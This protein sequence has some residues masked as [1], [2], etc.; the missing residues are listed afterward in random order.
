MML[1]VYFKKFLH[2]EIFK[3]EMMWC[4]EIVSILSEIGGSVGRLTDEIRFAQF[5]T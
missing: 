4:L 1:W 2:S 5:D 3:N